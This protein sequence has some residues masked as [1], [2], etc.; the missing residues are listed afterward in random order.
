MTKKHKETLFHCIKTHFTS[1]K[2]ITA[3]I[4][5]YIEGICRLTWI[6]KKI[7]YKENDIKQTK[8]NMYLFIFCVFLIGWLFY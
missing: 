4:E 3:N 2:Y 7:S 6:T 1:L 5:K 8:N